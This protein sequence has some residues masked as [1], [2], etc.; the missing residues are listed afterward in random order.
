MEAIVK[1]S[2]RARE[3]N[4]HLN[5]QIAVMNLEHGEVCNKLYNNN[6]DLV[7]IHV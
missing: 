5:M 4:E 7:R 1:D 3:L 2:K 6:Y